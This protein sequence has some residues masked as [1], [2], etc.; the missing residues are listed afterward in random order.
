M[1][2]QESGSEGGGVDIVKAGFDVHK[3][4]IDFE[5]G[6]VEGSYLVHERE[7]GVGGA[8]SWQGAGLVW[9][10]KALGPGEG[11][12][13]D[14][15]YPLKDFRDGFE[16]DNDTEGG[17]GIVGGLTRLVQNHPVRGF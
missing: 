12:Q 6:A 14:P 17:G 13:P 2:G 10:E 15:H 11:G 3:K 1:G 7:A 16:E 9:R 8:E 5:P 4:G